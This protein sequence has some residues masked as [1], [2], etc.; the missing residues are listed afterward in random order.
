VHK[1]QVITYL[2]LTLHRLDHPGIYAEKMK[3]AVKGR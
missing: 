2:K 1:A 3:K